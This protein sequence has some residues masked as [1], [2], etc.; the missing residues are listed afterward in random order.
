MSHEPNPYT[1]LA[2]SMEL[3][4]SYEDK[5]VGEVVGR[6]MI[7]YG[8]PPAQGSQLLRALVELVR[9][10][11]GSLLAAEIVDAYVSVYTCTED[12]VKL[13][14]RIAAYLSNCA[15]LAEL[16]TLMVDLSKPKS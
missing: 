5:A 3:Y 13:L 11:E 4:H 14:T 16:D 12:A 9:T 10:K 8:I 1:E 2:Q 15:S 7:K 6:G